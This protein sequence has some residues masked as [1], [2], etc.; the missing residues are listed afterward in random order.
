MI[1]FSF[2]VGF[3]CL[4]AAGSARAQT[5]ANDIDCKA[6]AACG[7]EV[8][9][10]NHSPTMTCKAAGTD[11][12]GADGWCTVDTDCKCHAQGAT[13][14]YPYCTFTTPAE[15]GDGGTS[16]GTAGS[17]GST[18]SAGSSG[19]GGGCNIVGGASAGGWLSL[20]GLGLVAAFSRRRRRAR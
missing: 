2:L 18:G 20:A 19:G 1:R 3:A 17:G 12:K 14:V 8:C 5:C 10:Y 13:C 7:G 6:N 4:L 15:A 16:T 9:D 11:P